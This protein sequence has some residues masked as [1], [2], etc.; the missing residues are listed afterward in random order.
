YWK[1]GVNVSFGADSTILPG[2]FGEESWSPFYGWEIGM[3]RLQIGDTDI[4]HVDHLDERL[5]L[6]Q[7]IQGYTINSAKQCD[8]DKVAGSIE[9]GKSADMMVL[10]EN[11]FEIPVERIHELLPEFVLFKGD[12]IYQG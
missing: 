8:W 3:T 9:V 4:S 7:M 2:I 6:E 1:T 10:K 11:P 5:T 12:V